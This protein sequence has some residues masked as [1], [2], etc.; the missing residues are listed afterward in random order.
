MLEIYVLA[1]DRH[2]NVAELNYLWIKNI[3]LISDHGR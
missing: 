2:K 3:K 1:W